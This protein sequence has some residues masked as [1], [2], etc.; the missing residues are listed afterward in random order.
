[1]SLCGSTEDVH[2]ADVCCACLRLRLTDALMRAASMQTR[3]NNAQRIYDCTLADWR[4]V[5]AQTCDEAD[6]LHTALLKVVDIAGTRG[7]VFDSAEYREQHALHFARAA[8]EA[9][10]AKRVK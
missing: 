7:Q 3:L 10:E 6:L 4:K 9:L 5:W 8:L 2:A 1:V